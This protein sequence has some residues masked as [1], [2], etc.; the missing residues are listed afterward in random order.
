MDNLH[1]GVILRSID[2]VK[3][4]GVRD[5]WCEKE[6]SERFP[7]NFFLGWYDHVDHMVD[8]RLFK[9]IYSNTVEGTRRRDRQQKRQ[10]KTMRE[11]LRNQRNNIG[12]DAVEA[13][14]G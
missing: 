11:S 10:I 14:Y 2:E 4:K 7:N 1:N 13:F 8:D 6:S 5:V 3:N 9:K 12:L